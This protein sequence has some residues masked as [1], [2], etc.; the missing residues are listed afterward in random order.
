MQEEER[1]Q[2]GL[3]QSPVTMSHETADANVDGVASRLA[4]TDC[5]VVRSV[6]GKLRRD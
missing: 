2:A 1:L 3:D 6:T 4:Q 5:G